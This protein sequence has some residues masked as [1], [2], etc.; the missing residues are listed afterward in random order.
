MG[1][2][3]VHAPKRP[4]IGIA[5]SGGVDSMALAALCVALKTYP[6]AKQ[7]FDFQFFPIVIDHKARERSSDEVERVRQR[8]I[9]MGTTP[10][11]TD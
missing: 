10:Q 3:S 1:K 6:L 7:I 5:V 8:L 11:M 2:G 4:K 9:E